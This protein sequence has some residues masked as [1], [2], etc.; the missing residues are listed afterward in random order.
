MSKNI[1]YLKVQ[2]RA[3]TYAEPIDRPLFV[4]EHLRG[5]IAYINLDDLAE[6]ALLRLLAINGV[7]GVIDARIHPVFARPRFKH[8][9]VV[10][11]LNLR[12]IYYFEYAFFAFH[13]MDMIPIKWE[14][15]ARAFAEIERLLPLGLTV[16]LFDKESKN[17]GWL[18]EVKH[19]C[20]HA[21]GFIT[22]LHPRSLIGYLSSQYSK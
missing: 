6:E 3:H 4:L 21:S 13:C 15:S 11:Y 18:E 2:S 20:T 14:K 1:H 12:K 19:I 17:L 10:E 22:E 16:C 8:R 5:H 7:S 9:N